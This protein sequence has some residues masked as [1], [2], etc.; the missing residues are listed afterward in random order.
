MQNKNSAFTLIEL[1]T[2]IV[3]ITIIAGVT[4]AIVL[5]FMKNTI[6]LPSQMNVQQAADVAMDIIIEGDDKAKGLRFAS[7][8]TSAKADFIRFTN[9]DDQDI[10]YRIRKDRL[11]RRIGNKPWEI[12]PYY[13]ADNL[14]VTR[15][16]NRLFDYFIIDKKGNEKKV[17]SPNPDDVRR[18]KINLRALS[19]TGDFDKWEGEIKLASSVK[20]YKFVVNQLPEK[21]NLKYKYEKKKNRFII[22]FEIYD[23]DG[24]N[25]DWKAEVEGDPGGDSTLNPTSGSGSV[26]KHG[27]NVSIT[28]TPTAGYS[29]TTIVTI[30][31]ED[32][33]GATDEESVSITVKAKPKKPKKV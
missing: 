30:E 7:E 19:G 3:I 32:P 33:E 29:G 5:F 10:R 25:V 26:G 15:Q 21:R 9:F 24:G 23:P 13:A 8:T 11:Q 22:T 2:V 31:V 27:Y 6:F 12:I 16:G 17:G 18:I 4:S 28:Y 1:I 14:R 20:L